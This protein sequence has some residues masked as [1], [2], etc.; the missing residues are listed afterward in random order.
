MTP[1]SVCIPRAFLCWTK[2]GF[3]YQIGLGFLF[4]FILF[5]FTGGVNTHTHTMDF[6]N[7]NQKRS[8]RIDPRRNGVDFSLSSPLVKLKTFEMFFLFLFSFRHVALSFL[9]LYY[10][11]GYFTN[12]ST[13]PV[14]SFLSFWSLLLRQIKFHF[15][16]VWVCWRGHS[17]ISIREWCP[18]VDDAHISAEIESQTFYPA[19]TF[20]SIFVKTRSI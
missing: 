8:G 3:S 14:S 20:D 7:N 18:V 9:A 19:I 15:W 17:R 4:Y 12:P 10:F 1:T 11:L 13:T 5:F 2:I 6:N 16:C